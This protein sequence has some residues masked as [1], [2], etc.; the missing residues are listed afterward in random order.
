MLLLRTAMAVVDYPTTKSP[1]WEVPELSNE[2][3]EQL[4]SYLFYEVSDR[5]RN[6]LRWAHHI[7]TEEEENTRVPV[8]MA[9]KLRS[10]IHSQSTLFGSKKIE[11]NPE[12][13]LLGSVDSFM[14]GY[15]GYDVEKCTCL[16]VSLLL[17]N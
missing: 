11:T 1:A 12:L 7:R 17:W 6:A 5:P 13:K 10:V 14:S 16:I 3:R 9:Y 2:E 4:T 15:Y 8:K